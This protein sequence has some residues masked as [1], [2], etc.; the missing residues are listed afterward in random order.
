MKHNLLRLVLLLGDLAAILLFVFVGQQDHG[1]ADV[2]HPIWGLLRASFPLLLTWIVLAVIAR[3]YPTPENMTKHTLF[4]R[5][6]NA[7]LIAA[8]LGLLLRG[9]LLGRG[10]IP[11]IFLLLTLITGAAFILIWRLLFYL[12]WR[13]LQSEG[14]N[15][16]F[17]RITATGKTRANHTAAPHPLNFE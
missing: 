14:R 1:T 6:L 4:V 12:V 7:W 2:N 5:A 8:P 10:G 16:R 3:A 11:N 15:G 17:S 9:Y 13:Q